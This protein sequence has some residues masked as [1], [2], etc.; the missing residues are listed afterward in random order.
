M[1]RERPGEAASNVTLGEVVRCT[2]DNR[3]SMGGQ[4][5]HPKLFS[6]KNLD[7]QSALGSDVE[8]YIHTLRCE[9]VLGDDIDVDEDLFRFVECISKTA[10]SCQP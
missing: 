3:T 1:L 10:T 9:F 7:D 5:A 6:I 4:L 2:D 8:L